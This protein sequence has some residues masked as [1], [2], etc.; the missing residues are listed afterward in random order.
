MIVERTT[1][2]TTTIRMM[3][4]TSAMV[5]AI[6]TRGDEHREP[7]FHSHSRTT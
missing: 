2:A 3:T 4:A 6:R 5:T 1:V 7:R